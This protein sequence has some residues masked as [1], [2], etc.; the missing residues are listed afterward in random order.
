ME[1]AR[2][3]RLECLQRLRLEGR[4]LDLY[5][6]RKRAAAG[7][8]SRAEAWLA[9]LAAC[10]AG[11]AHVLRW[12]FR[13]GWPRFFDAEPPWHL[14]DMADPWFE[15]FGIAPQLDLVNDA[16]CIGS[17]WRQ[18]ELPCFPPEVA[19]YRSAMR[20]PACLDVLLEAGARSPWI[21]LG[22]WMGFTCLGL[23]LVGLTE[24]L[25]K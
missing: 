2:E 1:A 22:S 13:Y 8:A 12:L 3:G 7:E 18:P 9:A 11:H 25:V 21:C 20:A 15:K 4:F 23:R 17:L 10:E 19:L 5:K 14:H 16:N 24:L 6:R